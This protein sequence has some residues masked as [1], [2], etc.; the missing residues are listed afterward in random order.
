MSALARQLTVSLGSHA[1]NIHIGSGVLTSAAARTGVQGRS[2]RV[3]TDSHLAALHLPALLNAFGLQREQVFVMDAGEPS[4]SWSTAEQVLDWMLSQKLSRDAVLIAF[5]GGV[6]GDMAGFCAAIYQR[7]IA[8]VQVPT[9]LL[10]MV[11]SSVGG[12]TGVNHARGKNLIGA[13]HQPKAVIADLDLLKTLPQRELSAGAAEV[14]KYGMLG[15]AAFFDELEAGAIDRLMA[16][17]PDTSAAVVERCCALKARI[18][19]EDEFET[20]GQR[21]LLNL[22]HT[23]GHAVETFTG[24]TQWLHG[25]AVGLGLVMAADLSARLGWISTE[26]ATRCTALVARAGL[27]IKPPAGM[28]PDDFRRLMAGDKKVAAGQLRFVLLKRLGNAVLTADFDDRKLSETLAH[29]C[30]K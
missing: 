24:Y 9:T 5:G 16:L 13:F 1:Y 17:D 14:I 28:T 6:I 20:T 11:D 25:E 23:F 15:D 30:A 4:K 19:A 2:L 12:K 26:D 10:A 21:A 22:G 29:F 8:F 7:G 18:V 3:I 27:P